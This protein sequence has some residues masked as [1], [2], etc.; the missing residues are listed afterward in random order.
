VDEAHEELL[1]FVRKRAAHVA[2]QVQQA[3]EH[4]VLKAR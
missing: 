3:L 2:W 4:G 1:D